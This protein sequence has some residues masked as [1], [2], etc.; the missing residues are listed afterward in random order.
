M[1]FTTQYLNNLQVDTWHQVKELPD[2]IGLAGLGYATASQVL[3]PDKQIILG[4]YSCTF[5]I[6]KVNRMYMAMRNQEAV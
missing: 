3:M 5:R 6:D 1:D 2:V 4:K